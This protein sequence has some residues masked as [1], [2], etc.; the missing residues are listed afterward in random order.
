MNFAS[1]GQGSLPQLLGLKL[2]QAGAFKLVH[3]PYG[4][5][6]PA[7]VDLLAGRI[8]LAFLN[9]PPLLP[10][11]QDGKL[12]ALAIANEARSESLPQVATMAELGFAGFELSTWYGISAPA[13]TPRAVVDKL[14]AAIA[15]VL[16]SPG[17]RDKISKA[18]AEV[19]SKGPDDYAAYVRQDATR[20]LPLI[21]SAGLRE[22]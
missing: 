1:V 7:L 4:G 11:I 13:G 8:D 10:H 3:V 21:D 14:A 2:Q 20:L 16:K 9:L 19:F 6:A 5:A 17:A 18:G 15:E 12:R 22:N